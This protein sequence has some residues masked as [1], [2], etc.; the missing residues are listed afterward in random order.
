M[1]TAPS[2]TAAGRRPEAATLAAVALHFAVFLVPLYV[3]AACGPGWWLVPLWLAYGLMSHG[4]LLVIHE[5]CHKLLFRN[6]ALNELVGRWL[7][8]PY[9][10]SDFDSFRRRH[11]EHHRVLGEPEDPKYTYRMEVAG[12]RFVGLVL[13]TL[14]LWEAIRRLIFQSGGRS[15]KTARS[16]RRTLVAVAIVQG[17]LFL[18][19]LATARGFGAEGWVGALRDA[20]WA[21]FAVH[22]YGLASL[23]VLLHAL[24]GIIEHQP[25]GGPEPRVG[26]AALRNFS[27][28]F[29]QKWLLGSYGFSEHATHHEHPG[30]PYYRLRELTAR[31]SA[32]NPDLKPVGGHLAVLRRL[33]AAGP[34]APEL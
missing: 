26:E 12:W 22:V 20:A 18:S 24:R 30:V 16:S 4:A 25:L 14:V 3:A 5:M 6:A 32:T 27:D 1:T 11:L 34:R 2:R 15:R 13:R 10:F 29:F 23:G 19:L 7:V 21:Y 9:F 31:E 28:G 17:A 8:G 33:V